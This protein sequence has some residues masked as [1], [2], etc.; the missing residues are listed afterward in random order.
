[1]MILIGVGVLLVMVLANLRHETLLS[2]P[3]QVEDLIVVV[4]VGCI[5][6]GLAI[7][8]AFR[9]QQRPNEED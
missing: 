5:I 4:G 7:E 6:V 2:R 8:D 3:V 1:M 9:R